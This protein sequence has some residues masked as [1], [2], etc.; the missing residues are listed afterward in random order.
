ML[1]LPNG[2]LNDIVAPNLLDDSTSLAPGSVCGLAW[3]GII[4][5]GLLLLTWPILVCRLLRNL[6]VALPSLL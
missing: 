5:N 6:L 1:I 2:L 3:F 4:S